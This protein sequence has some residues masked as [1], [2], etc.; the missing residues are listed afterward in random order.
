MPLQAQ[1]LISLAT[2]DARKP[3]FTVQAGEYLNQ[4]LS[5][6]CFNHDLEVNK[7]PTTITLTGAPLGPDN[8]QGVTPGVGPYPLPANYLRMCD[9][10]IIYNLGGAPIRMIGDD[11]AEIDFLGILPLQSTY[12][13]RFAT[14]RPQGLISGGN[15]YVWPP[16]TFQIVLN[17]RYYQLQADIGSPETS[18]TIPWFPHQKYL[19]TELTAMLLRPNGAWREWE[20]DAKVMLND[21]LKM[22]KDSNTRALTIGWDE[23]EWR[24]RSNY[25]NLPSTKQIP[26]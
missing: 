1:Q 12:P 18:A 14:D 19:Q 10:E 21:F 24:N 8:W 2:Q 26:W 15:L 9:R 25:G 16:P 6:L 4:I 7:T 22:E 23:R 20:N 17:Y 3:G 13:I 5:D 11:L